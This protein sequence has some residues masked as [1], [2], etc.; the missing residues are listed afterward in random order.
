MLRLDWL[1]RSHR[2]VSV[3]ASRGSNLGRDNFRSL[4]QA[5]Y[6]GT[7]TFKY[8]MLAITEKGIFFKKIYFPR[9]RV[10]QTP[11]SNLDLQL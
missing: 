9:K 11:R 1:V 5:I 8:E 2:R 6:H 3:G 4:D 7:V 10:N